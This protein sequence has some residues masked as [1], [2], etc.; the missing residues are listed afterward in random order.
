MGLFGTSFLLGKRFVNLRKNP[1]IASINREANQILKSLKKRL[2]V[3]KK[4]RALTE[5]EERHLNALNSMN[6]RDFSDYKLLKSKG[7]VVD[8]DIRELQEEK[9]SIL[10]IKSLEEREKHIEAEIVQVIEGLESYFARG[11]LMNA[12]HIAKLFQRY[13]MLE[14][15]F[16]KIQ[17][18]A[19]ADVV[20]AERLAKKRYTELQK[21]GKYGKKIAQMEAKRALG[22]DKEYQKL[23][24]DQEK[25]KQMDKNQYETGFLM[26]CK[27]LGS[28]LIT[29]VS[30][31]ARGTGVG[32]EALVA[33]VGVGAGDVGRGIGK[34]TLGVGEGTGDVG[35]GIGK[36]T[37]GTGKAV[38]GA[39]SAI[40]GMGQGIKRLVGAI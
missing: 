38:L 11:V 18:M 10:A 34:A 9:R 32:S 13:Q 29:M 7:I 23:L 25:K 33:G 40:Q 24:A 35:R 5:D 6:A 37:H 2:K 8:Q 14:G 15:E 3:A 31:L 16:I 21:S 30:K 39:G 20:R 12:Q 22:E 26:R 17:R 28:E 19:E 36:A 4:Q 1:K 27:H